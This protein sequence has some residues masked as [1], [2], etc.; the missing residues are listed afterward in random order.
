MSK[1]MTAP[2]TRKHYPKKKRLMYEE[3]QQIPTQYNVIAL[4]KMSKVRAAQLMMI[5]KKF[6]NEVQIKIIKNKVA[7]RAFE[8]VKSVAGIENL[9]NQ[10]EDQCALIFT[11]INP[12]K[13]NLIFAQNKVF[14][15]AKGGDIAPKEILVP[16]GNTGITPGPVLSEFKTANVP[17]K[18]DQGTIWVS[19]DT[20]VAK[21]GDVISMSLASLLSKLNVK[22]I[23]A[24]ISVNFAIAEGLQ[25]Q[26]QD[27][28]LNLE[29]YREELARSFAQ[30]LALATEAGYMTPETV[31]PLLVKAHQQAISLAVEAGYVTPETAGFVLPR[32]EAQAQTLANRAKEK[33]Y[34]PQ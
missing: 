34:S 5:R 13:L 4:S 25:F 15:P 21:P 31:T 11:N 29:E 30:A 26:E 23:E 8:K 22:P 6:R 19:K 27:L 14:L 24:G 28:K 9:S 7:M 33:G 20:L 3:L 32:A 18:I 12:F 2:P 10:L 16:A 17:T 1:Q